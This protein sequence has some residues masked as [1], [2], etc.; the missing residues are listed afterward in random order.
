MKTTQFYRYTPNPTT[1]DDRK[2]PFPVMGVHVELSR[3]ND[4]EVWLRTSKRS[5][6]QYKCQV[7]IE[8][9]FNSVSA[10]RRMDV[11]DGSGSITSPG[12]SSAAGHLAGASVWQ[13]HLLSQQQPHNTSRQPQNSGAVQQNPSQVYGVARAASGEYLVAVGPLV[14]LLTIGASLLQVH[15]TLYWPP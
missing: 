3:S 7:S 5:A 9:T 2:M 10:E 6:G 1:P 13:Q 11:V 14:G 12:A 8:G 15:R 4:K